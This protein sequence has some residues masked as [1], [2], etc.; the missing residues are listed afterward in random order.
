VARKNGDADGVSISLA[1]QSHAT[2][3]AAVM[4]IQ[5]KKYAALFVTQRKSF[6]PTEKLFLLR[7]TFALRCVTLRCV[8]ECW[9]PAIS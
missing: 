7:K 3:R 4:E 9:K 2:P 8:A 6:Y 5:L 1:M